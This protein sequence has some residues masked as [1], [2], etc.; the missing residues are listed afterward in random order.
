MSKN[1]NI[2]HNKKRIY[3]KGKTVLLQYIKENIQFNFRI[4]KLF[5]R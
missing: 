1:Y 2:V 5:N 3:I 4:G